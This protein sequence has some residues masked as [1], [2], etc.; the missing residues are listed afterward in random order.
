MCENDCLQQGIAGHSIGAVQDKTI[1][2]IARAPDSVAILP[3]ANLDPNPDTGYFSDGVTEEILHRLAATRALH[4][5]GRTSSFAFRNSEKGP[6]EI[7]EHLG[8]EYLL[9]GSIRRDGDFV[10]VTARLMD[11]TGLQV[12]SQTFDRKL[13]SIFI[14]QSEIASSVA[15]QIVKEIVSSGGASATRV[16][17][18]R[19]LR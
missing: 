15:A 6:A 8:V 3:F 19:S 4:V 14:I 17:E 5:L 10:R 1:S 13:E 7:S 16:R 11:R 2:S 18:I 9:H 12:W